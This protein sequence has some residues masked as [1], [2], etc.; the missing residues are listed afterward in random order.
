MRSAEGKGGD[1]RLR[2]IPVAADGGKTGLRAAGKGI[3]AAAGIPGRLTLWRPSD[4]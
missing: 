4:R 3:P 2:A 1:G